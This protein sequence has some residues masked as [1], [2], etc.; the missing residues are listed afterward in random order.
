MKKEIFLSMVMALSLVFTSVPARAQLE[1]LKENLGKLAED[2]LGAVQKTSLSDV[3][4][5]QG[6]KEAL[7]VGITKAVKSVSK[8]G[9]YFDNT[10]IKIPLPEQLQT[11]DSALRKI[12][13]TKYTD[14]FVLSMNRAAE[15]AAPS[16][17]DIFLDAL[18]AMTIEDVRKVYGGGDT[19]STE[20]FKGKTLNRLAEAFRP[21]VDEALKTYDVTDKYN[22]LVEKY[23]TIPFAGSVKSLS[24]DE[25]VVE[26]ALDGLFFVLGQ[27]ETK[28]RRDPAARV[29]DILKKVFE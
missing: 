16:A 1:N 2:P 8:A 6:L 22:H 27:Q 26:K 12:G 5:G 14:D 23:E 17:L 9:G 28:I 11:V 25:Y 29:T 10:D 4:I 3:E 18:A 21:A 20:Y 7:K 13:M 15:S 19:A 24:P